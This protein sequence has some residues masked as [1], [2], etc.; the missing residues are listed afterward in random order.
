[1]FALTPGDL[2]GRI[3]DCAAGPASFNAELTSDGHDVISCDPVYSLTADEIRSRIDATRG[4]VVGNARAAQNEFVWRDFASPEHLGEVRMAAMQ[5]FLADFPEGLREGR[6]L[7][8]ALPHLDFHGD[9]FDL[10]LCSH[11]LFTY[12]DQL[13]TDFHVSAIQ[14]MCRVAGEARV[15]PLLKSYGGPSPHLEPVV[16]A[17][18]KRGYEAEIREVPYEFQRGGDKMLAVRRSTSAG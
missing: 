11:F 7:V 2:S 5:R 12:S 10:A 6:Y 9:E 14:E 1:M 18:R 3:L 13:S 17:L 16:N 4:T 8:Q 15:F